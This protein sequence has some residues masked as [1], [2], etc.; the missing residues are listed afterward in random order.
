MSR[1]LGT[2]ILLE[3]K[4]NLFIDIK[5]I[6]ILIW[7]YMYIINNYYLPLNKIHI[8]EQLLLYTVRFFHKIQ[9]P[10]RQAQLV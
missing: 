5:S 1:Q 9:L 4:K 2:P 8:V 10:I 6:I 7:I 3:L